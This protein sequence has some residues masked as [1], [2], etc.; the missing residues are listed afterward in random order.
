M[1]ARK[2]LEV[3]SDEELALTTKLNYV[4]IGS[5]TYILK[6]VNNDPLEFTN[7]IKSFYEE[8]Y[9]TVLANSVD[10]S[11]TEYQD[12]VTHLNNRVYNRQNKNSVV[13]PNEVCKNGALFTVVSNVVCGTYSFLYSPNLIKTDKRFLERYY[14][15][16]LEIG[17]PENKLY[18]TFYITVKPLFKVL[19]T[20]AYSPKLGSIYVL[21]NPTFHT[22][23]YING[24]GRQCTGNAS[25]EEF[26][27]R[28]TDL[29]MLNSINLMSLA[30]SECHG[31]PIQ[32]FLKKD[33][34]IK[35]DYV[36]EGG[37]VTWKV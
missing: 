25:G 3:S 29:Q 33:N 8:K 10:V 5:K 12:L 19:T 18:F 30:R 13:V 32:D 16:P 22:M 9:K 14:V 21:G 17:I 35:I 2:K 23:S 36:K 4:R 6:E 7:K 20:L 26:W 11:I 1:V 24:I 34:I 15:N 27:N 31:V 37:E 28:K